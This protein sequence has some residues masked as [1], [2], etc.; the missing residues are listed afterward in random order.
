MS[1]SVYK[2]DTE[3]FEVVDSITYTADLDQ[4]STWLEGPVSNIIFNLLHRI[5]NDTIELAC[6]VFCKRSI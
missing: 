6:R 2:I 3:T 1:N 4:S 5:A